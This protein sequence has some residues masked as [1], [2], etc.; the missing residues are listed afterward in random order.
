MPSGDAVNAADERLVPTP[1]PEEIEEIGE[2]EL[3]KQREERL[4]PYPEGAF[5][6]GR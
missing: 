2:E 5:V 6:T 3:E 4:F 1:T